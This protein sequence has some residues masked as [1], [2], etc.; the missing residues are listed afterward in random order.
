VDESGLNAID[1]WEELMEVS[2]GVQG[3][4]SSGRLYH[5]PMQLRPVHHLI[6]LVPHWLVPL[7]L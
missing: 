5:M 1:G 6:I 3:Q 7:L 4:A 2:V